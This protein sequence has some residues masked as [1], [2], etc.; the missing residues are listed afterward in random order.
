MQALE[1]GA[2]R[3]ATGRLTAS[4]L[5]VHLENGV[6]QLKAEQRPRFVHDAPLSN[7]IVF[8]EN[9]VVDPVNVTFSFSEKVSRGLRQ[10]YWVEIS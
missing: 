9:L 6:Q 7:D 3:D 1:S 10:A 5:K 2:A 8:S 4:S